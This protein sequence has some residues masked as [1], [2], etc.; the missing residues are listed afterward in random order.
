MTAYRYVR[1]GRLRAR[2]V[3]SH[4]QVR[5]ADLG[6]IVPAA[7]AGRS[8]AARRAPKKDYVQRLTPLLVCGDEAEAWRLL[9]SAL[10]SAY[11]PED[12]YFDVLGPAMRRV[13]DGWA[14]GHIDI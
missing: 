11:G 12:V 3:G 4:W 14:A 10:A 8:S 6:E 5:P 7:P 13:G 9:Q 1:T 2:R